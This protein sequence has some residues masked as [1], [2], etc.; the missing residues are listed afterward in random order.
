MQRKYGLDYPTWRYSGFKKLSD[1]TLCM[2]GKCSVNEVHPEPAMSSPYCILC[3]YMWKGH[4]MRKKRLKLVTV[5]ILDLLGNHCV[6]V[7]IVLKKWSTV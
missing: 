5:S 7:G 6:T 1:F 4:C 2:I 3:E